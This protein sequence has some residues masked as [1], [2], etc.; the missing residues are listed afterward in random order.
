LTLPG[1]AV[2]LGAKGDGSWL[3]RFRITNPAQSEPC[4]IV[5]VWDFWLAG[6]DAIGG[7]PAAGVV[8]RELGA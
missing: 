7:V 1:E 3:A 6:T 8:P 2:G 5:V 4:T